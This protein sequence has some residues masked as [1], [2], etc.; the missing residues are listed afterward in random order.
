MGIIFRILAFDRLRQYCYATTARP[1]PG[2]RP[3]PTLVSTGLLYRSAEET[4]RAPFG[5]SSEIGQFPIE[6]G[7]ST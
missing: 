6:A 3:D 2:N 5:S 1:A 7:L 4:K